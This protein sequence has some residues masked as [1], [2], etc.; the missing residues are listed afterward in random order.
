MLRAMSLRRLP[1]FRPAEPSSSSEVQV[2]PSVLSGRVIVVADTGTGEL[3]L[4]WAAC[5]AATL[6]Q[7]GRAAKIG[8]VG[9][10]PGL[11]AVGSVQGLFEPTCA[12]YE[13]P[14]S[15][16]R[17]AEIQLRRQAAELWIFAGPA[18]LSAFEGGLSVLLGADAPI[19][20]WPESAR[21]A[22][23][24]ISL[25]LAGDGLSV[26]RALGQRLGDG[27]A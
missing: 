1:L 16:L 27:W 3:S 19:L 9:F 11:L 21:R 12:L 2:E 4:H 14:L 23:G 7:L 18:T 26:A 13:V 8:V 17:E 25:E 15:G 20:R 24:R 5:L 6:G 10:E 22:R